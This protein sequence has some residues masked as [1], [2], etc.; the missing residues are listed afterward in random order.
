MVRLKCT[1]KPF[2]HFRGN[3]DIET[4]IGRENS[5]MYCTAMSRLRNEI[6]YVCS[7]FL[8]YQP[9]DLRLTVLVNCNKV[10][11]YTDN[12]QSETA[13]LTSEHKLIQ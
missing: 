9:V 8:V 4:K 13:K 3:L 1:E 11:T 5:S 7:T 2:A 6:K 10:Q 12:Y